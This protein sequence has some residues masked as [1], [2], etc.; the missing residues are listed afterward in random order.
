MTHQNKQEKE[1]LVFQL[2]G[3]MGSWG[4]IACGE[5]RQSYTHPTKSAI[6]G[7]IAS[8]FGIERADSRLQELNDHLQ[9]AIHVLRC[10]HYLSDFHTIQ[11][12]D[13][14][15]K[16]KK[17]KWWTRKDELDGDT[18]TVLSTREYW[19]DLYYRIAITIDDTTPDWCLLE[20]IKSRLRE[21]I[22]H[23]YLGRKSCPL[24]LPL[25]PIIKT[26]SDL[27]TLFNQFETIMKVPQFPSEKPFSKSKNYLNRKGRIFCEPKM[28]TDDSIGF[29]KSIKRDIPADRDRDLWHFNE[30]EELE[31]LVKETI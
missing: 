21:P 8:A 19:Q 1:Y 23:L 24:G 15:K 12:P 6:I 31:L 14:L 9:V 30:R 18:N 22:F 25:S 27:I 3:T 26:E 13:D 16:L 5:R 7:L 11:V 29:K 28:V 17:Q 20:K 4:G 10:E 2:A